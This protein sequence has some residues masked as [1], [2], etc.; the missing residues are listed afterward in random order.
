[1]RLTFTHSV[2]VYFC[3]EHMFIWIYLIIKKFFFKDK[4]YKCTAHAV[5]YISTG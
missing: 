5:Q 1:M 2:A 3:V 4:M